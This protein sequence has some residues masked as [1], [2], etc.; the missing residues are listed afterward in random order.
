MKVITLQGKEKLV[1]DRVNGGPSGMF[2]KVQLL[3]LRGLYKVFTLE[4]S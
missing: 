2:G 1:E 4:N 3:D